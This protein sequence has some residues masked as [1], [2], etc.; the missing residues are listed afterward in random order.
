MF[1]ATLSSFFLNWELVP[2]SFATLDFFCL[3]DYIIA[4][5]ISISSFCYNLLNSEDSVIT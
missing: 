3:F 5:I 4:I 2:F 1:P